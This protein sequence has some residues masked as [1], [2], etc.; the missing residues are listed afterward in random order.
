MKGILIFFIFLRVDLKGIGTDGYYC[1]YF[2]FMWFGEIGVL[3]RN[4]VFM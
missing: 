1:V 3:F 2:K 4:Y